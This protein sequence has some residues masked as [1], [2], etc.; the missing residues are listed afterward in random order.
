[1]ATYRDNP[2]PGYNF[3][4]DFGP[5]PSAIVGSFAEASGLG[6]EIEPIEYRNGSED[7]TVRKIPGL[8]KYTNVVLK[9]GIVGDLG[10]W[11]WIKAAMDGERDQRTV[12]I[13]LLDENREAV[14]H[15]KLR[16]AWPVKWEGPSLNA[17]ANE[18]AI[19]TLEL[20]H[21]G[22]EVE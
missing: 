21:E 2:Y 22:L 14:L 10:V 7:T 12:G 20:C 16:N 18:V 19:E 3:L 13:S 6:V 8:K 11:E 15:F 1:M 5:D 17:T 4:V 9:R